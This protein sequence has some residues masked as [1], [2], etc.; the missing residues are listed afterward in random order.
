V[1]DDSTRQTGPDSE[2]GEDI[3][4]F[5]LTPGE[6]VDKG[7]KR[8]VTE[9]MES[10][11]NQLR[12][13]DDSLRGDCIHEARK[14]I[15][16][17]RAIVRLLMPGLGAAGF[18]DNRALRDAGRALSKLRDAAALIE[19][20]ESLSEQYFAD[21]AMEQLSVVRSALRRNL[22]DTVRSEDIR[23]VIGGV[24]AS[25]KTLKKRAGKWQIAGG[26]FAAIAPGLDM[27]YRRGRKQLRRAEAEPTSENL[28][29]LRKRIKDH[30][31]HVRLL[32]GP[33]RLSL[34]G[35]FAS[36]DRALRDLQD[37]LGD[38]HNLTV[39]RDSI[40]ADPGSFGGKKSV[41]AVVD[42][43]C[44]AQNELRK[45]ALAG[46][47]RIYSSKPKAHLQETGEAWDLWQG[48]ASVPKPMAP[49]HADSPVKERRGSAA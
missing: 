19:T 2:H 5:R 31:Y 6:A 41:P 42:L 30:W 13:T 4:P 35:A 26:A 38:D 1:S 36:R 33:L 45:Q 9:E 15:K 39:L 48:T 10:A 46:A 3:M 37:W 14:S 7:L 18:R 23:T 28:H 25:L 22:E 49:V 21:P 8:I 17:V 44:R 24:V 11:I 12:K 32:D 16:K 20:V 27:T 29:D 34:N 43:I 40:Q 47:E